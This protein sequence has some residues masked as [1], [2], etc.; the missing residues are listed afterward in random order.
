MLQKHIDIY[1]GL[2]VEHVFEFLEHHVIQ[3]IYI[4]K[5]DSVR[6]SLS[7]PACPTKL[8]PALAGFK[9]LHYFSM[10]PTLRITSTASET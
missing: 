8:C 9:Q 4:Y 6:Q 7:F 10:C 3:Y 5:Q 1:T 2:H